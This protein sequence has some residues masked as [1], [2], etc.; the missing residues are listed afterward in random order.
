MAEDLRTALKAG[1]CSN[2][3]GANF[4]LF[5]LIRSRNATLG[6]HFSAG[7]KRNLTRDRCSNTLIVQTYAGLIEQ[8]RW[9]AASFLRRDKGVP[10]SLANELAANEP[11]QRVVPEICF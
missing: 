5:G 1:F 3:H 11:P 10:E 2:I 9:C 7:L 6:V 4:P 8:K